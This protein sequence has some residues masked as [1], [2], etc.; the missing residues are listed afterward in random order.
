MTKRKNLK[1]IEISRGWTGFYSLF[2]LALCCFNAYGRIGD[3]F[4]ECV[5]RYGK[6]FSAMPYPPVVLPDII[7]VEPF[8][9]A[10]S[11][12]G[13]PVVTGY[14][15]REKHTEEEFEEP[16]NKFSGFRC[17]KIIYIYKNEISNELAS[18]IIEKN[19]PGLKIS[20]K[21]ALVTSWG[22]KG[23]S[24]GSLI[25]KHTLTVTHR[26]YCTKLKEYFDNK[27]RIKKAKE[28]L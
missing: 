16:S 19:L 10:S 17:V 12:D 26:D 11:Q 20:Q 7:R 3:S 13:E 8:L 22:K 23:D 15:I 9:Q 25:G 28:R 18:A 24:S 2:L 1:F 14:F 4:E 21:D 27:Q 6:T 5:A